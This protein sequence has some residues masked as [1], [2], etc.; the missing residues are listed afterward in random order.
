MKEKI[1]IIHCADIH[2]GSEPAFLGNK[3]VSRGEEL[4]LTFEKLVEFAKRGNVDLLLIAGDLFESNSVS[5]RYFN[6][7]KK[8]LATIPDTIVAI[9]TGNHDP[10]SMDSPYNDSW[11][12]NVYIF[13][14]FRTVRFPEKG[15]MLSGAGF[16]TSAQENSLFENVKSEEG[17]IN[18]GIFHGDIYNLESGKN[19][20]SLSMIENSEFD[21]IALGHI[22]ARS[23]ITIKGKTYYSY[24]GCL[25]GRGFDESGI[26]GFYYGE[27]GVDFN[28]LTFVQAGRRIHHVLDVD[29]TNCS[30][31][32]DLSELIQIEIS[33]NSKNP[34]MDLFKIIL[35]GSVPQ[36]F[37]FSVDSLI[38]RL[39]DKYYYIKIID[40]TSY[41][42]NYESLATENSLM[43]IFTAKML[44]RIKNAKD[45]EEEIISQDA[46]NYGIKASHG[47]LGG[48]YEN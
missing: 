20:I 18:I 34:E 46:L 13:S 7:V 26:K 41:L 47:K 8:A 37:I 17:M 27:I 14:H 21:Y 6:T 25:E 48:I 32:L 24:S 5:E 22:H 28:R 45:K 31:I 15:F 11:G 40:K 10:N 35:I 44:E 43:G 9:C 33:K 1:K 30:D 4:L 2:L 38:T 19:P 29:V 23:E 3:A 36:D 16:S 39:S 12:E 42:I